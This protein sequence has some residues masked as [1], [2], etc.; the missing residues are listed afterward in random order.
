M[1]GDSGGGDAVGELAGRPVLPRADGPL[2]DVR[3]PDGQHLYAVVKGRLRETDGSWW[4]RLQIHLPSAVETRGRRSEEPAPVDFV[5]AA[6]SC[7]PVD[8][9]DYRQV[10][11]ERAGHT[12]DWR[13]EEP[14]YYGADT[15]PALV[16][17]RGDCHAVRDVSRPA[18]AE[19]ARTALERHGAAPCEVCRPDRPL[20][21]R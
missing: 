3:L 13:I 21:P 9:Q 17:H 16:V 2:V 6:A 1:S 18:T 19:Q 10:P 8:G 15:G 14:A 5:A 7:D 4:Y 20:L 12:P 11:T